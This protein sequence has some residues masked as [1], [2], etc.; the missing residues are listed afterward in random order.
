ME[1]TK[2]LKDALRLRDAYITFIESFQDSE[3]QIDSIYK[4]NGENDGFSFYRDIDFLIDLEDHDCTASIRLS[5]HIET[6]YVTIK[7]T[8]DDS[9][10]VEARSIIMEILKDYKDLIK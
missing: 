3:N 2:I 6:G 7:I 4:G 1:D 10:D 5:H 8:I 9:D